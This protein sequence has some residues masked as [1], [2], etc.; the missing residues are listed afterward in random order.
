MSSQSRWRE[1][2]TSMLGSAVL[3]R[4]LPSAALA[5]CRNGEL[6][7]Q[8]LTR[9]THGLLDIG[10]REPCGAKAKQEAG[11]DAKD[12]RALPIGQELLEPRPVE[13]AKELRETVEADGCKR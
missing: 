10:I 2:A 6:L 9:L 8:E 5:G 1:P 11:Q 4:R 3:T 12:G 13:L 7:D